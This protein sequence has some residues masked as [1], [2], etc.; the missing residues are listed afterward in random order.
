MVYPVPCLYPGVPYPA[1]CTTLPYPALYYPASLA[2][3]LCTGR[4]CTRAGLP[5]V[6]FWASYRSSAR[7]F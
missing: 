2:S 6:L 5:R 7:S 1:L 4:G 3:V